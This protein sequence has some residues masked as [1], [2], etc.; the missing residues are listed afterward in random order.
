MRTEELYRR[1]VPDATRLAFLLTGDAAAAQDVVHD[2]FV[3]AAAKWHVMRKPDQF[4]AYLRR[5]VVRTVLMGRRSAEREEARAVRAAAGEPRSERDVG[6][7]VADRLGIAEALATLPARQ[8]AALVLRYWH[9][10]PEA[11]IAS[12]LGFAPGTVKSSLSRGLD[13]LREVVPADV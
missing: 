8:R 2:A 4:G 9:D 7:V 6:A 12:V 3:K 13:A 10:L 1:H 5:T 11:E